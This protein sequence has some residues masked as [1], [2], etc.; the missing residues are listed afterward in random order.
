M[1]NGQNNKSQLAQN[2]KRTDDFVLDK[3]IF[4]NIFDKDIRRVYIYKKTERLAKALHLIT[5]AF[6]S[7]PILKDRIDRIAIELV[8][9]S[10]QTSSNA[11]I[12]LSR[13]LLALSSMLSVARAGSILSTMNADLI[14]QEARL[15]LQEVALYEEPRITFDDAPTIASI[16]RSAAIRPRARAALTKTPFKSH[17]GHIGHISDKP[18]NE[19]RREA[20]LAIVRDKG[21]VYIKDV[22]T[23]IRGVSEKTVQRELQALVKEGILSKQGERRWTLYSLA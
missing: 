16:A 10:L 15:L 11:R 17:K 22:S 4:S 13:E 3:D 9:A 21:Q 2:E 19:N 20:V 8:D 23:V 7:T 14:A 18:R 12:V 1:D 6:A 5:P